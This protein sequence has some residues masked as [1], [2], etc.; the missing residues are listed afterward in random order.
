[1]TSPT[2]PTAS[3]PDT[4]RLLLGVLLP[5]IVKGPIIRR[6]WA[7]GLAARLD[8]DTRAV[9]IVR[10]IHAK[11][12]AGPLMLKLPIR[13]Q[14]IVLAPE[15]ANTVLARS[16]EPFTPASSEKRAAL[17]HFQPAN[18]LITRGPLRTVRRA[19]QE[20]VL[21]TDHP[22]H[23]LAD[24]FVP[25]VEEE[26]LEL[27][28]GA[29]R[30][31]SLPW[32]DFLD[33]WYRVVRRVVFGDHA[34]DDKD[35]TAMVIRLRKDGNWAFLKP[36]RTKT[37]RRF[38]AR[39]TEELANAEP[40]SLAAV[41]AAAPKGDGAEPADQVPQW[42]FAFDPA[43][44]ATFRA[45]TVLAT[46]PEAMAAAR[47]EVDGDTSGRRV[48]PYL[49]AAILESLRLWP[50]TPMILRQTTQPVQWERG[51]MPADCGV[52]VYAPY[53]HRDE[54][55]LRSAHSFSPERWLT[56]EDDGWPL[57]PFSDGPVVC[58]G[59]QLVLLVTS[60]AL[61]ALVAGHDFRVEEGQALD[62]E[63]PLPGTM[64]NYSVRL[65]VSGRS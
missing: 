15:D 37:R 53:F 39:I 12:P 26:M 4:A 29:V 61:A 51:L 63:R 25:V 40:G 55:S 24:R 48:L 16:P 64:D 19:L 9:G 59:K 20:Q 38:L 52:L 56:E 17:S 58:P 1:M 62:P 54:R 10:S 65:G 60:A 21:D 2:L 14:A 13:R 11:H 46:H 22:V 23:H 44:M 49:R 28:A 35:L 33:A 41:M 34:R 43:G 30:S 32:D 57:V 50:T 47:R 45:L 42:L 7:V 8:L 36:V 31:G 3:A 6:P 18:V 27:L 5:T